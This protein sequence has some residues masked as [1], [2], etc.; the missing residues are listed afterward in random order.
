M[1]SRPLSSVSVGTRGVPGIYTTGWITCRSIDCRGNDCRSIDCRINGTTPDPFITPRVY[2]TLLEVALLFAV[3]YSTLFFRPVGKGAMVGFLPLRE[4][5]ALY[6]SIRPMIILCWSFS[7]QSCFG[8]GGSCCSRCK[9]WLVPRKGTS[10]GQ[11]S[12][13][14]VLKIE[15]TLERNHN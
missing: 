9:R 10:S 8:Q 2:S 13:N 7:G 12:K 1:S 5:L 6:V 14:P 15:W 3:T 11:V 4:F